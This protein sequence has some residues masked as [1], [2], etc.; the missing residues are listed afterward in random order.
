[1]TSGSGSLDQL[2]KMLNVTSLSMDIWNIGWTVCIDFGR[3]IMNEWVLAWLM[4]L[5]GSKYFSDN[6]FEGYIV[7]KNRALTY[8][9][10][11]TWKS[12]SGILYV[13]VDCWYHCCA[14]DISVFRAFCSLLRST[15]NLWTWNEVMS[16]S[17]Y[18]VMFGW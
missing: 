8:I 1:M 16:L 9:C 3:Q 18:M 15:T 7:Q 2:W 14:A 17:R 5:K 11:L 13:Y 10:C 6:F 4:I 12:R